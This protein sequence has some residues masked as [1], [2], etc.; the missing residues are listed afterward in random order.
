MIDR[1]TPEYAAIVAV[2]DDGE[3]AMR[4]PDSQETADL[5]V[6]ALDALSEATPSSDPALD[7]ERLA[8]AVENVRH[9]F[10]ALTAGPRKFAEQLAAEYARLA[11]P[12]PEPE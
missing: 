11:A 2:L 5:I 12:T 6:S 1:N 3:M 7:V 10:D 8:R 9:P 4:R